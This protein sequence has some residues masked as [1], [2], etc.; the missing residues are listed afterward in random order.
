MKLVKNCLLIIKGLKIKDG[1]IFWQKNRSWYQ[2]KWYVIGHNA[3]NLPKLNVFD[4]Y[5]YVFVTN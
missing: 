4:P 1:H 2:N 3:L 5:M